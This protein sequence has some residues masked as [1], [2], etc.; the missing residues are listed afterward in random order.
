ME[1]RWKKIVAERACD[2]IDAHKLS[3]SAVEF[4]NSELSPESLINKLS[5]ASKW[6]D[7]IMV[8][9]NALPRREAVWWAC[10]CS[11][12]MASI[13]GD[14]TEK[15]ALNAAEK[16]VYKPSDEGRSESFRLAQDSNTSSAGTLIALA[17]AYSENKLAVVMDQEIELDSSSFTQIVTAAVLTAANESPKE[18]I[19]D[20]YRI[21]INSGKDI[22]KGGNG[23]V[24]EKQKSKS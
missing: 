10:V 24:N 2:I 8:M 4:L 6:P 13:A 14:E 5:E 9:A 21:F 23:Q 3:N 1:D 15:R 16:W 12:R 11:R 18:Q 17:V 7:A 20:Q 19:D 22:A